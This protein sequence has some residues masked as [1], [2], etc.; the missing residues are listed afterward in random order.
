LEVDNP[1]DVENHNADVDLE[2]ITLVNKQLRDD[3]DLGSGISKTSPKDILAPQN[4][5]PPSPGPVQENS[6]FMAD[7][8]S[9][10]RLTEGEVTKADAKPIHPIFE[11]NCLPRRKM[12]R[13]CVDREEQEG[14]TDHNLNPSSI[15]VQHDIRP[16][17]VRGKKALESGYIGSGNGKRATSRTSPHGDP[18]LKQIDQLYHHAQDLDHS[19]HIFEHLAAGATQLYAQEQTASEASFLPL[20]SQASPGLERDTTVSPSTSTANHRLDTDDKFASTLPADPEI[21]EL[22]AD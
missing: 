21:H 9:K 8:K 19:A 18:L 3:R 14:L 15:T 10:S 7:K 11:S 4:P 6:F 20:S 2:G 22:Q 16:S 5:I 13:S 17:V 12:S 1:I